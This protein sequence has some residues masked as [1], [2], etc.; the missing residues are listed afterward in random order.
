MYFKQPIVNNR[1][2]D[3]EN[4][5]IKNKATIVVNIKNYDS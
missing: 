3:D 4:H 5:K 1:T 2:S